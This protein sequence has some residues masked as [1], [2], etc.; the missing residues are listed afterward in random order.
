MHYELDGG[1]S[2]QL[3]ADY[4]K[5]DANFGTAAPSTAASSAISHVS[6]SDCKCNET[7]AR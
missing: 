4:L 3:S 2:N 5:L 1:S 7:S 6:A